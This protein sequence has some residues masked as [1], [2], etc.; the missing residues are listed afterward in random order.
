MYCSSCGA[1]LPDGARYCSKCGAAVTAET[2]YERNDAPV[3]TASNTDTASSRVGLRTRLIEFR[4]TTLRAVPTFVLVLIALV[5]SAGVAYA[6]FR[7][8]TDVVMPAIENNVKAFAP[9]EEA[10]QQKEKKEEKQE[11][12]EEQVGATGHPKSFLQLSEIL[13]MNPK[14]ISSYLQGQGLRYVEPTLTPSSDGNPPEYGQEFIASLNSP[15]GST[16]SWE[17]DWSNAIAQQLGI[18]SQYVVASA[19]NATSGSTNQNSVEIVMGNNLS[20]SKS[21]APQYPNYEY[22]SVDSLEKG[23]VPAQI[24]LSGVGL[25]WLDGNGASSVAK[26]AGFGPVAGQYLCESTSGSSRWITYSGF[27]KIKGKDFGWAIV[28]SGSPSEE[29]P[30][31]ELRCFSL[32]DMKRF[33]VVEQK[34]YTEDEWQSASEAQRAEMIGQAFVQELREPSDGGVSLNLRTGQL[35]GLTENIAASGESYLQ[36]MGVTESSIKDFTK[37]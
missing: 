35:E 20:D 27:T 31:T 32:D 17:T 36:Y 15:V 1:K 21:Y 33:V 16:A 23:G 19:A 11:E 4:R 9:K 2:R 34:L 13:A 28:Q 25:K 14:D 12:Q 6:L 22:S 26:A 37:K 24:V 18:P 30:R 8:A 29:A 3:S 10:Q 5:A 7:V